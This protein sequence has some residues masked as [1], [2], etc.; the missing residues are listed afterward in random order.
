MLAPLLERGGKVPDSEAILASLGAPIASEF[1]FEALSVTWEVR[2]AIFAAYFCYAFSFRRAAAASFSF[3]FAVFVVSIIIVRTT[4]VS[5]EAL[6]LL[7]SLPL[8]SLFASSQAWRLL[9][10]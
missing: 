5:F 7:S 2:A 4:A 10:L 8:P 6:P 3:C 1:S 9:L